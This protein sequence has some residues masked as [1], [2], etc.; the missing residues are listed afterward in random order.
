MGLHREVQ[1]EA[2]STHWIGGCVGLTASLNGLEQRKTS[3][4][5]RESNQ[6]VANH[7]TS[8]TTL[9]GSIPAVI[10]NVQTFAKNFQRIVRFFPTGTGQPQLVFIHC[11][12]LWKS[13]IFSLS[14]IHMQCNLLVHF[15][16]NTFSVVYLA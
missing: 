9:I 12:W 3:C 6:P 4:Q 11:S 5:H 8:C 16:C 2:P 15:Q 14:H 7:Y 13:I 1:K 10:Q